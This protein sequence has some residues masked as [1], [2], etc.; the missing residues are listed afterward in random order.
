MSFNS[1]DKATYQITIIDKRDVSIHLLA[2]CRVNVSNVDDLEKTAFLPFDRIFHNG[3]DTF[4]QG[5]VTGIETTYA[6]GTVLLESGERIKYDILVLASGSKWEGALDFPDKTPEIGEFLRSNRQA[7][8]AASSIVLAGGGAVGIEFAGEIRDIW[9]TKEITVVHGG[10]MLVNDIYPARFRQAL[11]KGLENRGIKV[12]LGDFIDD[13]PGAGVNV[14][15]TRK[16]KTI[17]ADL[18][19]KTRG[20]KPNTN[21]IVS[22][23]GESSVS[24][25]GK[26]KVLST[27]Q[28]EGHL[29]IF[30][31]GD[32]VEFK[33]Q[34]QAAKAV[35]HASIVV[36]NIINYFNG[37]RMKLYK[38]SYEMALITN[39]KKGGIAYIGVL[40]GIVLGD[41]FARMTKSPTLVVGRY[42]ASRGY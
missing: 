42:A 19:L 10:D 36:A 9:P 2:V 32:I 26:V 3:N 27:M 22:S 31:L 1:L 15:I 34:S 33:E 4:K 29:N 40:W 5:L 6:A 37:T 18:V 30:A 17:K 41:W 20:P 24:A 12:I 23:L 21:F 14:V 35:T 28:L 16:G 7:I 25:N 11:Q 38:G 39:G 13:F 8:G